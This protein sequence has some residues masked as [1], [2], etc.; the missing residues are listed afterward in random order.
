MI[1]FRDS[2]FFCKATFF[3]VNYRYIPSFVDFVLYLMNM[4]MFLLP[5]QRTTD[6]LIYRHL[7]K[8]LVKFTVIQIALKE[9]KLIEFKNC[10]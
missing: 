10:K 3:S 7:I 1:G 5:V 9:L 4:D 6:D 2:M 8:K